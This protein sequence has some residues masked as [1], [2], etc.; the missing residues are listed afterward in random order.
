ML[1][2]ADVIVTKK[3]L[4]PNSKKHFVSRKKCQT[5]AY[6]NSMVDVTEMRKNECV[7]GAHKRSH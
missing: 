7:M 1:C 4:V 2:F 6:F 3:I 5:R